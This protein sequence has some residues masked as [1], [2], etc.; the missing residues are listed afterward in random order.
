[1]D[2]SLLQLLLISK[3]NVDLALT[4]RSIET[5]REKFMSPLTVEQ[6]VYARDAFAKATYSRLFTWLVKRLNSSLQESKVRILVAL[7]M[8]YIALKNVFL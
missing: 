1:M 7:V 3:E 2:S 8:T 4:H 5:I 6:A